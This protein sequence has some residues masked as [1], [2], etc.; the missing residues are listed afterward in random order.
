M[1]AKARD[2]GVNASGI[3]VID[4]RGRLVGGFNP[5]RI[6]QLLTN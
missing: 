4:V 6:E 1:L 3:P 2:Q 5:A